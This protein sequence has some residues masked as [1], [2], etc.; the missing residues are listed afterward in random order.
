MNLLPRLLLSVPELVKHFYSLPI[1]LWKVLWWMWWGFFLVSQQPRKG[2]GAH[3]CLHNISW[4]G[5]FCPVMLPPWGVLFS[6]VTVD[7]K[8]EN[9]MIEAHIWLVSTVKFLF[10]LFVFASSPPL[11]LSLSVCKL[12]SAEDR[13]VCFQLG[14]SGVGVRLAHSFRVRNVCLSA[15]LFHPLL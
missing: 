1:I 3:C 15:L 6:R 9:R 8:R 14:F 13:R 11:P 5:S 10:L 12:S 2:G 7:S 4:A